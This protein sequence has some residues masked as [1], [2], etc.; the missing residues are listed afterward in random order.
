[1]A[2]TNKRTERKSQSLRSRHNHNSENDN[3]Q[4][5]EQ[6][7]HSNQSSR[8]KDMSWA[9]KYLDD[10]WEGNFSKNGGY[11]TK[12]TVHA[13]ISTL[14]SGTVDLMSQTQEFTPVGDEED[15]DEL[16]IRD[17]VTDKTIVSLEEVHEVRDAVSMFTMK[18]DDT[19]GKAGDT[20]DKKDTEDTDEDSD[21]LK[22]RDAVTDKTIVRVSEASEVRDSEQIRDAAM[23]AVLEEDLEDLDNIRD[24]RSVKTPQTPLASTG[25]FLSV[26]DAY[27]GKVVFSQKEAQP[28]L[29][30]STGLLNEMISPENN[31]PPAEKK[32]K[33]QKPVKENRNSRPQEPHREKIRENRPREIQPRRDYR[34]R[35]DYYRREPYSGYYAPVKS[36]LRFIPLVLVIALCVLGFITARIVCYDIPVN[37]SDYSKITY[38]V[39]EDLTDST[40]SNDLLGLGLIDNP[41]VFKLRCKFYDA[42]YVPGT[43]ELSPCYST[44]KIINI[45]SGYKYGDDE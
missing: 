23:S 12:A 14:R 10:D 43:Y 45:L 28:E 32:K 40:L 29:I 20:E 44:E 21:E 19:S 34:E 25:S 6:Q 30:S 42:D 27:T 5:Q 26:R 35:P 31:E 8:V 38:T 9:A 13:Q 16:K 33:K 11:D 18:Q 41:L 24:A 2:E 15:D 4:V 37:A 36:P 39:T 7:D 3:T 22:I 17:A 1:M